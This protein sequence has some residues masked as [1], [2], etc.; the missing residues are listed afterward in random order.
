MWECQ[1]FTLRTKVVHDLLDELRC[2]IHCFCNTTCKAFCRFIIFSQKK[3]KFLTFWQSYIYNTP[4][5]VDLSVDIF[6]DEKMTVNKD[7]CIKE[8]QSYLRFKANNCSED[9][10]RPSCWIFHFWLDHLTL[11]EKSKIYYYY[12]QKKWN[13]YKFKIAI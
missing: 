5:Y 10:E 8:L 11:L 13:F 12:S 4:S 6:I 2:T 7:L 9:D 3:W 1:Q